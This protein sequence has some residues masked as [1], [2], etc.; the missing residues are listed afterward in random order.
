MA[1]RS[2]PAAHARALPLL[3]LDQ[4]WVLFALS[5]IAAFISLF[6]TSPNDFWWH[7]KAG[8]LVAT[9]SEVRVLV[10]EHNRIVVAAA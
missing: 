3:R 6:P 9:G 5:L 7:L 1:D 8:E 2:T 4:L 10:I